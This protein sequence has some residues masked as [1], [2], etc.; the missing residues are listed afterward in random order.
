MQTY[1]KHFV[2]FF[3]KSKNIVNWAQSQNGT[4]IP[5]AITGSCSASCIPT[6]PPSTQCPAT[7]PCINTE[8]YMADFGNKKGNI[9]FVGTFGIDASIRGCALSNICK[10]NLTLRFN[11]N[12]LK[13]FFCYRC[14]T[15]IA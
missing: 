6:Q 9:C 10:V 5:I 15:I 3:E 13:L 1:L 8:C 11:P 12:R 2:Y 4:L 14:I 7:T